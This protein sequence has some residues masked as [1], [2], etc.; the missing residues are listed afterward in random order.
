MIVDLGITRLEFNRLLELLDARF[1][2][3]QGVEPSR[4]P[5]AAADL[6]VR[7]LIRQGIFAVAD[8]APATLSLVTC[9]QT[10]E[11]VRD[12]LELC[13][14]IFTLLKPGGALCLV[15]HNRRAISARLLGRKSPIF[16]IEHMQLFSPQ[17]LSRMLDA[18]GFSRV[19]VFSIWNRYPLSYWV[20]LFPLPPPLKR[21]ALTTLK[22]TRLGRIP[23]ALPPGNLA[24][25]AFRS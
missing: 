24:A 22:A 19:E 14:D 6:Q 25:V 1:Q 12:P 4:A 3:V 18:S 8:Y 10:I 5:I 20:R 2:N 15:C 7:S 16:D 21:G 13:R 9:F 11:H 17:S 23:F